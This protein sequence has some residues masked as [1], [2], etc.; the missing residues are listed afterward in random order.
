MVTMLVRP[1]LSARVTAGSDPSPLCNTTT[2]QRVQLRTLSRTVSSLQ[3]PTHC[4]VGKGRNWAPP[5]P[6][7]P[8]NRGWR[9]EVSRI[10]TAAVWG[11]WVWAALLRPHCRLTGLGG[12]QRPGPEA[13]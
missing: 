12:Q 3:T 7:R 10:Q 9:A 4:E 1:R 6:A 11:A 5:P 2:A 8:G 13:G